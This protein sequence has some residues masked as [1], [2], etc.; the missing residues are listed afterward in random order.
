MNKK[1]LILIAL[2]L[3]VLSMLLTMLSLPIAAAQPAMQFGNGAIVFSSAPGAKSTSVGSLSA[4]GTYSGS[5]AYVNTSLD[6]SR[7]FKAYETSASTVIGGTLKFTYTGASI[8]ANE[9][10][11][12]IIADKTGKILYY[13][14]LKNT[15]AAADSNG[16]ISITVPNLLGE[17]VYNLYLF[18]EC[19]GSSGDVA[20]MFSTVSLLVYPDPYI[21]TTTI[22]ATT[23][24]VNYKNVVLQAESSSPNLTWSIQSGSLPQGM[25]L[26]PT[27]G[28]LTGAP[29]TAGTYNFTVKA[30]VGST[31]HTRAFTLVVNPAI[32][33]DFSSDIATGAITSISIPRGRTISLTAAITGGTQPYSQYQW[34]VNGNKISGANSL[35]YKLPTDTLGKYIYT[36]AVSDLSTANASASIT[37]EVREPINPTVSSSTVKYDKANPTI[38]SFTKKDGDYPFES[39]KAGNTVLKEGTQY[40]INGDTITLTKDL[41]DKLPLGDNELTLDYG[42][43]ASD[44]KITVTV[45]DTS[46]PPVVGPLETPSAINRGQKLAIQTPTVT[47]Y[48]APITAQGWKIKLSDTTSFIDFNAS[49]KLECSYNKATVYYYA[50]NSAGTTTSNEVIIT[51]NHT[52]SSDWS[53]NKTEH[54]HV[55]DCGQKFDLAPHTCNAAG[56]CTVCGYHCTHKY[57]AYKSDNNATCTTDS[58][59]SRT[60]TL[61]GYVDTITDA[62]TKL[63]HAW[64]IWQL[65][66]TEHWKVCTRCSAKSEQG[67]HVPGPPPTTTSPQT[68]TVCGMMLEEK[69]TPGTTVP[70]GNTSDTTAPGGNTPGTTVPGGNTPGTTVP[71]GNTPGTT[72]PGGNTPGTTIP[73]GNTNDST[74]PGITIPDV[75]LDSGDS[76]TTDSTTDNLGGTTA[77]T[78]PAKPPINIDRKPGDTNDEKPTF[79]TDSDLSSIIIITV[80]KR[81]LTKDEYTVT[82]TPNGSEI[83][84]HPITPI[85]PGDHTLSVETEDGKGEVDFETGNTGNK[86]KSGFPYWL[87]WVIPHVLA[88]ILGLILIIILVTKKKDDEES[89]TTETASNN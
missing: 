9:Y 17:T 89:N 2:T 65:S 83:V 47:T 36:F 67:A 82:V 71:G 53:R 58:T 77:P 7:P 87:L 13:G 31:Y 59:S 57:G 23:Q 3:I 15:V 14:K 81:P 20:S 21:T 19:C 54:W 18:S 24:G 34:S 5:E 22:P 55:C 86:D 38:I 8:G 30:A 75:P 66:P 76:T 33:I 62:G 69:L 46:L 45:I 35:T 10:V 44:P 4:I 61:C 16:I 43:T 42:D 84:I 85:E 64:S 48:G 6:M 41:L 79:I 28:E 32:K 37:V 50:T 78:S 39:I 27:T 60:C 1:K 74:T 40:T 56:D 68:C 29:T 26:N 63:G 52:P 49:S 73:G 72:V 70:G 51:V 80:D 11:S 88:D 25:Y 12:A